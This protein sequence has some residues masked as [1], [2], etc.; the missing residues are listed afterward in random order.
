MK[1]Q[2]TDAATTV[3]RRMNVMCEAGSF[4]SLYNNRPVTPR[5][6]DYTTMTKANRPSGHGVAMRVGV[7]TQ[8]TN[9]PRNDVSIQIMSKHAN[10]HARQSIQESTISI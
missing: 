1:L 5:A 3:A 2:L 8:H 10:A 7:S 9:K 4:C 6:H